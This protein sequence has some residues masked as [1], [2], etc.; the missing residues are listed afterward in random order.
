MRWLAAVAML[1]LGL[2]IHKFR[3]KAETIYYSK[4][5]AAMQ[6][7]AN[8]MQTHIG[9]LRGC[10]PLWRAAVSRRYLLDLSTNKALIENRAV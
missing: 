10:M 8:A 5:S 2:L 6:C 4:C 9:T 1:V 3:T 7:D